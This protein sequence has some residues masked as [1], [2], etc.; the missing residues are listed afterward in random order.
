MLN[1]KTL[2]RV[3]AERGMGD[4]GGKNF[5]SVLLLISLQLKT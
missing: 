1:R 3:T 4:F 5:G 2:G